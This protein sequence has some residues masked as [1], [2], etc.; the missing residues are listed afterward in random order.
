MI[1]S[2]GPLVRMQ[3]HVDRR[4]SKHVGQDDGGLVLGSVGRSGDVGRNA[5][6]EFEFTLGGAVVNVTRG[7][8]CRNGIHRSVLVDR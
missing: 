8:A 2:L 3:L 6:D 1:P 4:R 5:V 7:A